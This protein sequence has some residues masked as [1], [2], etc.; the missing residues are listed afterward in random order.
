MEE[1]ESRSA[2]ATSAHSP[3]GAKRKAVEEP[4][5]S[6]DD[7]RTDVDG[8]ESDSVDVQ[9]QAA[10]RGMI[11][12]LEKVS[13]NVLSFR[14]CLIVLKPAAIEERTGMIEI[15]VV[16]NDG[17]KES[18]IILA[19]LKNLFQKQL[20]EMPKDY[21]A[22]LVYDRTHVSL[23]IV[24]TPLQ[25]VGGITIRE[26]RS[27]G[28]AEIVFC[29]ITTDQQVKGY[30]QHIMAHLK[31][32]VRATS[33]IMHF[34]TYADNFAIGYFKKQGFTAE[35]TFPQSA[36]KGYIKDYEGGTLMQCTM[37]PRIYYLEAGRM[38]QK[39][40]EVILAKIRILS[41]SNIVYQPPAQWANGVVPIDPQSVPAI[42]ASGWSP[43]MD[44]LAQ[45]PHRGPHFNDFRRFLYSIQD[46]S[47][48]WPFLRPVDRNAIPDYYKA[49]TSPMDL[50][51]IEEKLD[52]GVYS[53]SKDFIDDFKLMFSNCRQYNDSKSVYAK[54]A[55]KVEKYMRNLVREVP[56]WHDLVGT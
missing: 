3:S 35:I 45:L 40:K 54:C 43:E 47:Q 17:T 36:W 12:F 32:Y 34:L 51:T 39:Q 1:P 37:L 55:A 44:D 56:E 9:S 19:G 48:A 14:R 23:A 31:D 50:S 30:G 7:P 22:R 20:P 49:I 8:N 15:R 6:P 5:A 21:I 10:N 52:N 4:D 46:H 33:S 29:A 11:T 42:R 28:F 27:R 25:V 18:T 38:L 24:K 13:K 2:S 16:N 41:K 53:T 26:F